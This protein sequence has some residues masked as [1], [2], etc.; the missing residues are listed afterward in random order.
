MTWV[1]DITQ[2]DASIDSEGAGTATIGYLWSSDSF[3]DPLIISN[4]P[5]NFLGGD[6]GVEPLPARGSSHPNLPSLKLDVYQVQCDGRSQRIVARYSNDARFVFPPPTDDPDRFTSIHYSSAVEEVK[7][8][9]PYARRVEQKEALPVG[10]TGPTAKVLLKYGEKYLNENQRRWSWDVIIPEADID[11]AE[12]AMDD[13]HNRLH[14]IRSR[15]WRFQAAPVE[16]FAK[17]GNEKRYR[18]TYTWLGDR[19]SGDP[20]A[21]PNDPNSGPPI[22]PNQGPSTN[23]WEVYFPQQS[24]PTNALTSSFMMTRQPFCTFTVGKETISPQGEPMPTFIQFLP[25]IRD[26]FGWQTLKGL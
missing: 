1:R 6:T 24:F 26:D 25:Y 23:Y 11:S 17:V 20:L 19:G 22:L 13:Q 21:N 7:V 18:I 3:V 14:Y 4:T 8:P 9:Y 16:F 12:Q 10:F 2:S 15:Y 5:Q